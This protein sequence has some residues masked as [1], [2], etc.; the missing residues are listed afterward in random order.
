M[1]FLCCLSESLFEAIAPG[2]YRHDDCRAELLTA[3][4]DQR[5]LAGDGDVLE[6]EVVSRQ[7]EPPR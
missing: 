3:E 7:G 6:G 5:L 1:N 2:V 4:F